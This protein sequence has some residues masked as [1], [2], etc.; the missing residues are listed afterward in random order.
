M[1]G[2]YHILL[3]VLVLF[4]ANFKMHLFVLWVDVFGKEITSSYHRAQMFIV[5]IES[6]KHHQ[7]KPRS[8]L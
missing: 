7:S 5:I 4:I 6:S 3:G 1:A 8:L 2:Q